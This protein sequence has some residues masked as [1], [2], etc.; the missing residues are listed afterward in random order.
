M[1]K[2]R[3]QVVKILNMPQEDACTMQEHI[4]EWMKPENN[5]R[6][7]KF[8]IEKCCKH[9]LTINKYPQPVPCKKY[10]ETPESVDL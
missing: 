1:G 2:I 10:I 8:Y 5:I 4:P 3:K 7:S 9:R 6:F